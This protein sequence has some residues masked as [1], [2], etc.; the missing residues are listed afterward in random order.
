LSHRQRTNLPA[1]SAGRL[2]LHGMR[3]QKIENR[4]RLGALEPF[5]RLRVIA[6]VERFA[7]GLRMGAHKR[8]RGFRL[9]V[10]GVA[11][12]G[13]HLL[14]AGVMAVFTNGKDT[15]SQ[16][17]DEQAGAYSCEQ[18]IR[19]SARFV[20]RVERAFET[21]KEN[22]EAA[23]ATWGERVAPSLDIV[24]MLALTDAQLAL[25]ATSLTNS[26]RRSTPSRC[27]PSS[28]ASSPPC[29]MPRSPQR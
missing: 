17:G 5:E 26:K 19:M 2:R 9:H 27:R 7:A 4:P 18:R 16:P 13:C 24:R 8:M 22:R 10:A 6:Y 25:I 3:H 21:G 15:P 28:G 20:E 1:E 23:V 11:H 29:G 14:V 12:L